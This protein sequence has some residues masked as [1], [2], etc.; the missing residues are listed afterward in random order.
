MQRGEV[1]W[2]QFDELRPVVLLHGDEASGFQV[3]QVVPPAEMDI[4]GLGVEVAIGPVD[5]LAYDGVLRLAFAHPGFYFCTWLTHLT[6]QSLVKRAGVLS[7][8]KLG[9]IDA[10]LHLCSQ[11][12]QPAPDAAARLHEIRDTLRRGASRAGNAPD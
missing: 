1:W 7:P 11:P 5:G 12:R 8:E 3:I 4:S 2:V 10:A 9:E 6:A